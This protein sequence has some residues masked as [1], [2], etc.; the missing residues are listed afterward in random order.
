MHLSLDDII[1]KGAPA[2]VVA[3]IFM[4]KIYLYSRRRKQLDSENNALQQVIEL[5]LDS[6]EDDL[7]D[8]KAMT[9]KSLQH[10]TWLKDVHD[11]KDSDGV[12]AWYVR[13]ALQTEV[14]RLAD[15]VTALN[16]TIHDVHLGQKQQT[17]VREA[18]VNKLTK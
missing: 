15:A 12:Y 5:K 7:V 11:V 1:G 10:S 2:L 8:V 13:K 14:S 9:Q 6:M 16:M 3:V 4:F 17:K 18:L